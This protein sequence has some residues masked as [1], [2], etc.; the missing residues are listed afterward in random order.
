MENKKLDRI[1][2]LIEMASREAKTP[3]EETERANAQQQAE[4]L[5]QK[6]SVEEW[7]IAQAGGRDAKPVKPETR[8]K[9]FISRSGH[10]CRHAL[11]DLANGLGHHLNVST[12]Y[13]G[14]S[15]KFH[16]KSFDVTATAIGYPED[17]YMWEMIFTMLHL[18]LLGKIEPQVDPS[19]SFD[20]NVYNLHAAGIK[21]AEIAR[22]INDVAESANWK[23]V[24]WTDQGD[25]GRLK[26]AS[27]RWAAA[28]GLQYVTKANPT[29]Y[30]H[31]FANAYVATV[32]RRVRAA[33]R[34]EKTSGNELVLRDKFKSVLEFRD[35]MFPELSATL[36]EAKFK[37]DPNG[38]L[39]G[40]LAGEQADLNITPQASSSNQGA[41][42]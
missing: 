16:L 7:Q 33:R 25:G 13:T 28:N 39:N 42:E 8:N 29:A 12:V 18:Q 21:W 27:R 6:Y 41:L 35:E 11:S 15:L 9:V 17:L 14:L 31:S 40:A 38:W 22:R 3:E 37:D 36:D 19:K 2:R 1:R 4:R 26:R 20:E 32:L 34:T 24:N 30:Q 23:P 10:P 5:M